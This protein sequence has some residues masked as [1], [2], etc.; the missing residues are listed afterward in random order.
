MF[1]REERQEYNIYDSEQDVEKRFH[2]KFRDIHLTME[3]FMIFITAMSGM[4][5]FF[6]AGGDENVIQVG[7]KV[8]MR[9]YIMIP[10]LVN[11]FIYVITYVLIKE[12][13]VSGSIPDNSK[14]IIMNVSF[15]LLIFS[16]VTFYQFFPVA[17]V[18]FSLPVILSAVYGS[19]RIIGLTSALSL[20]LSVLSAFF[21]QYDKYK[22]MNS[23]YLVNVII[24]EVLLFVCIIY[25]FL[26]SS[27]VKSRFLV[28]QKSMLMI[29]KLR[30]KLNTDS[31]TGLYSILEF[32][33]YI[34][35]IRKEAPSATFSVVYLA[36]DEFMHINNN[37]GY[38]YGDKVLNILAAV[39][40]SEE[41]I[42]PMRYGGAEFV[43]IVKKAE[44]ETGKILERLRNEFMRVC[45][46]VLNN[47]YI[48]FSAGITFGD[49]YVQPEVMMAQANSAMNYARTGEENRVCI[50]NSGSMVLD[51][52]RFMR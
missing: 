11:V 23:F 6:F 43:L 50:F 30:L 46:E 44:Y 48:S 34:R 21:I 10:I 42:L 4:I 29:D 25:A 15:V 45:R 35:K 51:E 8:Y 17:Y 33:G 37:F 28:L 20:S 26:S 18:G 5:L 12:K 3:L 13:Y 14:N 7:T 52:K 16:S 36:I 1:L 24:A 49:V 9:D 47:P 19:Y 39:V 22:I 40:K 31:V 32:D 41:Y 2:G 38:A 27:Y